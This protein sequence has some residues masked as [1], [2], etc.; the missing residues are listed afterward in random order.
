MA[1]YFCIFARSAAWSAYFPIS[2]MPVIVLSTPAFISEAVFTSL[3][4][5]NSL[6]AT[7]TRLLKADDE[8][9]YN[10]AFSVSIFLSATLLA[11]SARRSAESSILLMADCRDAVLP[12]AR[13]LANAI[14]ILLLISSDAGGSMVVDIT[15]LKLP[16]F[17]ATSST[18]LA[19]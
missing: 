1:S 9:A 2:V 18:T 13:E 8:R 12:V 7:L 14:C 17:L 6:L 19:T 10:E 5:L 3:A 16:T 4:L 11:A 15:L